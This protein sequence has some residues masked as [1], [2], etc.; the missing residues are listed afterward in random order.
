M[1]K[2]LMVL[3]ALLAFVVLCS[4]DMFLKL[5]AYHLQPNSKAVLQLFNGTFEKSDNVIDRNRML[6]VSLVGNGKRTAVD[7]SNWFEKND[8]TF[9]NFTTGNEGTWVA[10]LSTASRDIVLKADDFNAY[11]KSDGVLEV[12]E[13][14][15]KTNTLNDDAVEKYAKHVKTIFQV[16]DKLSNDWSVNLGY[17][18]EFMPLQNP[19]DLH[20]GHNLEVRLLYNGEPLI[21]HFVYVGTDATAKKE[22]TTHSHDGEAAHSHSHDNSEASEHQH[23]STKQFKTNKE[24]IV[25][26]EINTQGTWYLRTIKMIESADPK[27]THESDWATLT[28]GI[29]AG[30]NADHSHDEV[31]EH[32]HGADTHTHDASTHT[33]E[34]HTDDGFPT[35]IFWMA[36]I[37]VLGLLFFWFN[38][39]T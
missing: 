10:G 5:D 38:R 9:L 30:H 28:F 1:K 24:G 14:R 17:P 16:G 27:L 37:V 8:I 39:K 13:N 20:P 33:H 18:L 32:E 12:L 34:A 35:Y 4:H 2:P 11:L 23:P 15:K 36:S 3:A 26:I 25:S 21:N 22:E 6:D 7:S 31:Q 29:G 19:Y